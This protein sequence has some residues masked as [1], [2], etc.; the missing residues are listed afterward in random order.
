M[1]GI[2]GFQNKNNLFYP[3]MNT[4]AFLSMDSLAE[5]KSYD[6]LLFDPLADR[7]WKVEEVSWRNKQVNWNN[8]DVVVIRSPW[9]YQQDPAAFLETLRIIN[10]SSALLQ[11]ELELVEWN[12][13]KSYLR[14]LEKEEITIVPTL[15]KA[16]FNR[17]EY[18]SFFDA[19]RTNEIIIKPRI[20]A[21]ADDTFR[22]KRDQRERYIS[23]LKDTF[24]E[25]P[26]MVQPFVDNIVLEGEFSL[27]FFG[28][29]YSHTILKTPKSSDF[30]VQEEH[31]GTLKKVEPEPELLKSARKT[32]DFIDPK[33]LYSRIDYVRTA[34]G[35][36]ALMELELI[37][38]SLYFNMDRRS[39]ERFARIFDR[40]MK[41]QIPS[42]N[43]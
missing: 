23:E 33:P 13:D 31:G 26:F 8:F 14:D 34:S 29:T 30:R 43:T 36:F 2:F 12:L 35:T 1:T 5:F 38:P 16:N 21:N 15:W 19:F 42:I 3:T 40:R 20:S 11:N 9:D 7:G 27:F 6:H 41:K 25:R 22:I 32:L 17:K 37:E 10:R 24:H 28:E 4:C 39:P 18:S